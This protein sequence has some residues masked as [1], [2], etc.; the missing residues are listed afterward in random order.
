MLPQPTH[1]LLTVTLNTGF[2]A[3]DNFKGL[4]NSIGRDTVALLLV[5]RLA[6]ALTTPAEHVRWNLYYNLSIPRV[7]V[8]RATLVTYNMQPGNIL[9]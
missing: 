9:L 1:G 3:G 8:D 2:V 5:H 7:S 6:Q 4:I